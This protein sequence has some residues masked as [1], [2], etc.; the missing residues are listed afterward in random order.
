MNTKN[1]KI[2][3]GTVLLT[4]IIGVISVSL[5]FTSYGTPWEKQTAIAES[6][7]Y[8]TKYFN[9]NAKVKNTSYDSKMDSYAISFETNEDGEFTIEYKSPNNFNISPGVQEYLSK[10]YKFTE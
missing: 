3:M 9:L 2:A 7:S 10:H 1:K 5:Y 6:K 8:I 4:S